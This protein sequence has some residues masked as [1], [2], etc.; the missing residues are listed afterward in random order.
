MFLNRNGIQ[1]SICIPSICLNSQ[2]ATKSRGGESAFFNDGNFNIADPKLESRTLTSFREKSNHFATK[3]NLPKGP[4][5]K[6]HPL[7]QNGLS[8]EAFG[9]ATAADVG[10][11]SGGLV[12]P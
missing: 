5:N 8:Q 3:S 2:S 4:Q 9:R 11:R 6:K 12:A 10:R 7:I 1:E